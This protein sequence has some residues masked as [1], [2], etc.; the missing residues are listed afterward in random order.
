M[1]PNNYDVIAEL[2]D[3]F[4]PATFDIPFFLTETQKSPGEVLELMSGTGRVSIPLLEAGHQLTCVDL[5]A[6]LNAVFRRKLDR[7]GLKADIYQMDICRLDLPKKFPLAILPFHSFM[8]IVS[9]DDQRKAF[10]RIHRH[11]LPGGTF[12]LTL[13]NPALRK[14]AVDGQYHLMH[15]RPLEDGSGS[16]LVWIQENFDPTDPQVV[17][18]LEF[19]EEYDPRGVMV[20]KR[21]LE[22]CFRFSGREEIETLAQAAGFRVKALYGDYEWGEFQAESSLFMIWLFER[23]G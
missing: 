19:F 6:E 11:L 9:P 14:Q 5:S 7:L 21:L 15:K 10:E 22:L 3:S 2:Y 16:L 17:A 4:V 13:R 23:A 1:E 18:A 8:H 12:I 20:S